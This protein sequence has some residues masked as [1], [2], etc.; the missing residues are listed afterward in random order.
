VLAPFFECCLS[1]DVLLVQINPI[2][3]KS[4]PTS[5]REIMDRV[6][7]ISFNAP[8]LRELAQVDFI[9]DC[10]RR[11]E[12]SGRGYREIFMHRIG[13]GA[14]LDEFAASS[15]MNAD[16]NFLKMLRDLGRQAASEWLDA[17]FS[18]LGSVSTMPLRDVERK[19]PARA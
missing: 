18:K 10:L 16:W 13:G 3:R 19:I 15:K 1:Q 2:E 8:L 7:E 11:G 6:N 17:N 5:A 9:N 4:T 14:E 12:L